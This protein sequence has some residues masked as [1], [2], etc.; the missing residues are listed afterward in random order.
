MRV[1]AILIA[2]VV[3]SHVVGAQAQR[4]KIVDSSGVG[5]DQELLAVLLPSVASL[6]S[7]EFRALRRGRSPSVICGEVSTLNADGLSSPYVPFYVD[8]VSKRAVLMPSAESERF[9]ETLELYGNV[10]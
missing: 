10:C 9:L 6:D 1:P 2:I 7:A 8:A 4:P 5:I 3:G